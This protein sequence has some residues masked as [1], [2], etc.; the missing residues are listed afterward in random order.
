MKENWRVILIIGFSLGVI[1]GI[2]SLVGTNW[3]SYTVPFGMM[4]GSWLT[5]NRVS[6]ERFWSGFYT[7]LIAGIVGWIV[8]L[9]LHPG[10]LIDPS[11]PLVSI[12][13]LTAAFLLPL[14]LL[15]GAFGSWLFARTRNRVEAAQKRLQEDKDKRKQVYVNRPKRKFKKNKP[16]KKMKIHISLQ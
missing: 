3:F 9:G 1:A 15:I 16:E 14:I 2:L 4:V 8:T 10:N 5:I 13:Q 6:S 7:S 11:N 12:L